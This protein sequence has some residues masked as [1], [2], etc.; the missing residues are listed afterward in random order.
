M[1]RKI[2]FFEWWSWFKFNNLRLVPGMALNFYSCV[3]KR[4]KVKVKS[5]EGNYQRTF[6]HFPPP[7]I[8]NKVESDLIDFR[9]VKTIKKKKCKFHCLINCSVK[10]TYFITIIILENMFGNI[11]SAVFTYG[12]I[13]E[14]ELYC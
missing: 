5:V 1:T 7:P 3:E 9:P 13:E 10:V 6:L 8:L 11:K 4:L 12:E 2:D 14:R